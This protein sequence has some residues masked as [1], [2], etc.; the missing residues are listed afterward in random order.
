MERIKFAYFETEKKPAA[1]VGDL[2]KM[3]VVLDDVSKSHMMSARI[4]WTTRKGAYSGGY[5]L[6]VKFVRNEEIYRSLLEK[7]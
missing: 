4:V 2:V 1:S 6:G 5:G 3:Q 7:L